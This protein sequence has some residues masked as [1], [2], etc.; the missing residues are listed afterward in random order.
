MPL[1]SGDIGRPLTDL[2]P[3]FTDIDL[4]GEARDVLRTLA[5]RERYIRIADGDTHY[6][7]RL[8][9]YRTEANVIDGVIITFTDITALKQ[10]EEAA[11]AAQVYAE[12]IVAT[13]RGPLLIL[14]ATLHVRSANPAFYAFFHVTPAETEGLLLYELGRGQWNIP[15][16]RQLLEEL[17]PQQRVLENFEVTHDFPSIGPKVMQLNAREVSGTTPDTALILLAIED[18]TV[19][20][21]A[22]EV[23]RQSHDELERQVEERST[24][25][26]H[27]MTERQHLEHE[28]QR[29]THFATLG[30]LAAGVSHEI[31]NPLAAIFLQV[32]LL[33]E[34]LQQLTSD[35]PDVVAEVLVDIKV[36]LARI[37]DLVQDYL[38]L[39]RIGHMKLTQQDLGTAVVAW[40]AE[41]QEHAAVSG[42]TIHLQG[43]ADLGWIAFHANTLRRAMLNLMHNALDTMPQG[44][45]LTLAG[46]GTASQVQVQV[47]DTGS[48]IPAALLEQIFAPLYTTKPGGT[49][50]GLYIVQEIVAVHGGQ[51]TVQSVEEHGSTFTITLPRTTGEASVPDGAESAND[52]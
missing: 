17:L 28:A 35:S 14:D 50:L 42:V 10:A 26:R 6:L 33:A 8:G 41:V 3:R 22:E 24:A 18:I 23:Q 44:G 29:V 32:D 46:Q 40:A 51:V 13:V 36:Q 1:R 11:H 2:A 45:T 31:R 7:V 16:L 37:D 47:Q 30:R 43:L 52:V 38:S 34:E 19:R 20:R 25:W 27:E 5:W 15:D 49:G 4:V 21:Q 9:P 12:S 48:G 39:V